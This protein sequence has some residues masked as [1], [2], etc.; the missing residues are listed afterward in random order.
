MSVVN[1][2]PTVVAAP[3]GTRTHLD[4]PLAQLPNLYRGQ[5]RHTEEKVSN[6]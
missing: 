6:K 3:P 4:L 1:V 5:G 2:I